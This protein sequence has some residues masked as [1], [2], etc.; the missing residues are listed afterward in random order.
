MVSDMSDRKIGRKEGQKGNT[1]TRVSNKPH[2]CVHTLI[3]ARCDKVPSLTPVW[4]SFS[5]Y[6]GGCGELTSMPQ[7]VTIP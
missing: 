2:Q 4:C 1:S 5:L 3:C 6:G 7:Y